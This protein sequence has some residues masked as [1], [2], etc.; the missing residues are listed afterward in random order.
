[1]KALTLY[2]FSGLLSLV[3][4]SPLPS[5]EG[6]PASGVDQ[7]AL[8]EH[9]IYRRATDDQFSQVKVERSIAGDE[10]HAHVKRDAPLAIAQVRRQ[11]A[12]R[13]RL[14]AATGGLRRGRATSFPYDEVTSQKP[15]ACGFS[16]F[17]PMTAPF[18]ALSARLMGPLAYNNPYCRL[19][20]T[21][22]YKGRT[23]R[24]YVGDKCTFCV[25]PES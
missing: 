8:M 5:A 19:P 14:V 22:S 3:A 2:A 15:T 11:S 4:A 9:E 17:D 10:L 18:V 23:V 12:R 1:M 25:S 16:G 6:S 20:V 21:L 24:A 7:D 13:G